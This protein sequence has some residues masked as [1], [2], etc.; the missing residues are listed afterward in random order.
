VT[1]WR[2]RAHWIAGDRE[3][4]ASVLLA[5]LLPVL[6]AAIADGP[7]AAVEVARIVCAGQPAMASL[8]NLCAAAVADSALPGCYARR[9]AEASRARQA[10]TRVAVHALQDALLDVSQPRLLT[11]SYSG[12]VARAL[13]D[14]FRTRPFELICAESLPGGEGHRLRDDL[15]AAGLRVTAVHDAELTTYLSSATAVVVGADAISARGWTNKV[16][17]FGLAAAAW[18]RGVPVFVMA[19]RDKA[20]SDR[21]ETRLRVT[22][23]FEVTPLHLATLIITETGPSPPDELGPLTERFTPELT[24]LLPLI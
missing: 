5:E 11:L 2:E 15:R 6:D 8:W 19:S 14:L 18:F 24:Y 20:V 16:G 7:S 23:P 12:S 3:R 13:L 1:N 22:S 21:L 4:G 17:T 10:L 9:R